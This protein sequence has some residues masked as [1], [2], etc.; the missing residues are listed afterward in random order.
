MDDT[1]HG[2]R[3]DGFYINN[4]EAEYL[5][6]FAI[7]GYTDQFYTLWGSA[8]RNYGSLSLSYKN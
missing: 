5:N 3:Q 8:F 6:I 4:D 1:F 7:E 2:Y